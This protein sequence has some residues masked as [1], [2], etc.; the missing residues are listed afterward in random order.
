MD[1]S[2]EY[3]IEYVFTASVEGLKHGVEQVGN[4]VK[5]AGNAAKDFGTTMSEGAYQA[6]GSVNDLDGKTQALL[7]TVTAL[8]VALAKDSLAAF[9]SYEDAMFGMATTVG[10]VGGTI[11]QAMAGIKEV[12]ANGL[13]SQTDAA[14]AINNLTAYGYSVSEATRLVQELTNVAMANR[15]ESMSVSEQVERLTEGIKRGSSQMLKTNGLM[16]TGSE[17]M[18]YYATSIGKTASELDSAERRQAIYNSVLQEG[19]QNAAVASAYQDSYSAATQRMNNALNDLKVAFGQVLA[20]AMTWIANIAS[21]IAKNRELVTTLAATAGVIAGA[22]GIA[23][24]L[25]KLIPV[26]KSAVGWF[27]GLSSA[28]KGLV[29]VL[30]ALVGVAT[31]YGVNKAI[32]SMGDSMS[33]VA[34]STGYA[35]D[36]MVD[37]TNAVG[38]GGGGGAVGAVRDLSKELEKLE[39]QY[40]DELKQIEQRHQETIDRLTTQIYEAN[41]DYRRAIDERNAEFAVSQAKEEKKHQEKVDDIM[42]Q[43]AF[44]QRYNNDYN[45][46]KLAN[47]EFALAKENA[48]YQKQ[49]QAAKEQLD[50]QNEYDRIAYEEKRAQY[51]A[52]LDE[53]LAFMNKHRAD[54]QEV[55]GWILKDEI[56][57]LKERYEEQKAAYLEQAEG[58]NTGGYGVGSEYLNGMRGALAEGTPEIK[59]AYTTLADE[60][61][62]SWESTLIDWVGKAIQWVVQAVKDVYNWFSHI[63]EHIENLGRSIGEGIDNYFTGLGQRLQSVGDFV[64]SIVNP[65]FA[66]GGYTG[67]GNPNEIAGVVHKGE[68]VLP[69]DMVD[70]TTGTPKALGSTYNIYVEGVF[71]TSAQER[72]KV[73]DQI[74]AAINQNNKSRLEASWQ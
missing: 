7:A 26:I 36:E 15:N 59:A 16:V 28:S 41:V 35:A 53:E 32:S 56:E 50:L 18:A 66:T 23:V 17:A 43:I 33:D 31:V 62:Q 14:R 63:G 61:G 60:V 9:S 38:G 69:Q 42:T 49:T 48:L 47:L 46:Q 30:T 24:A 45:R 52:E 8:E 68:Y 1:S 12:T 13:L 2:N 37:F 74:V 3:T 25:A 5:Q 4:L 22:G 57:A 44:L 27:I 54:L 72:R 71:A 73:A 70:Q 67:Q 64:R 11:E 19:Q 55:R 39:R 34:S 58:A 10:N 21:W 20:P 40:K 51:Q 29:G 6:I 65:G